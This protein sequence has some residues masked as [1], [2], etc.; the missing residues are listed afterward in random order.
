MTQ[1]KSYY[2]VSDA[3]DPGSEFDTWS[4]AAAYLNEMRRK[5]PDAWQDGRILG[6][7]CEDFD[8]EYHDSHYDSPF[9]Y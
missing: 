7:G 8:A 2:V 5:Y 9:G 1:F 3:Q 6:P 4:E